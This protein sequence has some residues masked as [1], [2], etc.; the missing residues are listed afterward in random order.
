MYLLKPTGIDSDR[1]YEIAQSKFAEEDG[2]GHQLQVSGGKEKN[3]HEVTWKVRANRLG[4]RSI[5][6]ASDRQHKRIGAEEEDSLIE[7]RRVS[8]GRREA[9]R[10]AR[11][12]EAP[13][14]KGA[15]RGAP[16]CTIPPPPPRTL[17]TQ[18]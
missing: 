1:F 11:G 14:E 4:L 6:E 16:T 17:L 5:N 13:R 8:L 3:L 2:R 9:R 7:R 12:D 18:M 15:D 10:R